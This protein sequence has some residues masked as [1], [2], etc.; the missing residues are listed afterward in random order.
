M[1]VTARSIT[2][3]SQLWDALRI[4]AGSQQALDEIKARYDSGQAVILAVDG[5]ASGFIVLWA[6]IRPDN[7]R[8][9]VIALGIGTG[10]EA[11]A[12]QA[13][14]IGL[15]QGWRFLRTHVSRP[16][17]V[18]IYEKCGWVKSEKDNEGQRIMRYD[19]GRIE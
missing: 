8:E 17:L 10:A 1:A 19:N 5:D 6:E 3:F 18:R 12:E 11:W 4:P 14:K 9:G 13:P 16:G 15:H 2:A 7:E